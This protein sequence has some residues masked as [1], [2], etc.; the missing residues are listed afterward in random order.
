ML[1]LHKTSY[2]HTLESN[3]APRNWMGPE[4]AE[5]PTELEAEV[6]ACR[7]YCDIVLGDL[8]IPAP[9]EDDP[10]ATE[11]IK[12][13]VVVSITAREIPPEPEA[14]SSP[15]ARVAE[16]EAAFDALTEG[17]LNDKS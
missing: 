8:A 9:T 13:G 6:W 7:G 3:G 16:L 17:L 15:E 10:E 5:V 2:P 11:T 12:D 4:W 1:I 14:P